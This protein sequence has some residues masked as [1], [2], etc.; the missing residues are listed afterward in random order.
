M[1][2]LADF[3]KGAADGAIT[4]FVIITG[5]HAAKLP[6]RV[7]IFLGLAN[8]IADGI[9]FAAAR[10][11]SVRTEQEQELTAK[12]AAEAA[13]FT[14]LGFVLF[15]M[16]ALS[17]YILKMANPYTMSLLLTII[18]IFVL[19]WYKGEVLNRPPIGSAIETLMVGMLAGGIAFWM[20]SLVH[21]AEKT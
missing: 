9:S 21:R 8:V 13:F 19:G 16:I 6:R 3:V 2:Y 18:S 10:F 5:T 12:N 15:G 17:S 1:K 7:T 4:T 11:L 20:G 14:W